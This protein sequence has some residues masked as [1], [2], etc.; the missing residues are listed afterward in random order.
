MWAFLFLLVSYYFNGV[1]TS[2]TR[3]LIVTV[4]YCIIL[5]G[6]VLYALLDAYTSVMTVNLDC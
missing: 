4:H 1:I 5:R 3:V 6:H 2:I